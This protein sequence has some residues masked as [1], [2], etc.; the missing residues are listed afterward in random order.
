MRSLEA[1]IQDYIGKSL[2]ISNRDLGVVVSYL[3]ISDGYSTRYIL[4]TDTGKR[5]DFASVV[6]HFAAMRRK[7]VSP[8][9]SDY[10]ARS[11]GAK[12]LYRYQVMCPAN[13]E[14]TV[15]DGTVNVSIVSREK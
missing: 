1:Q 4:E 3:S 10:S 9:G 5:I 13:I 8:D 11:V 7:S 6:R 2:V 14:S 12:K 15:R